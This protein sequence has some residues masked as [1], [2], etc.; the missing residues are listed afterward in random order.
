MSQT[1][2][3]DLLAKERTSDIEVQ[4]NVTFSQM[5]LSPPVLNGLL[6]CG[7][8]KPSP[9]QCKSIPLG[10]CGFGIILYIL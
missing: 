8:H 10:R 6:K 3:H 1:I 2:A 7:F 9:I 4:E 5:G